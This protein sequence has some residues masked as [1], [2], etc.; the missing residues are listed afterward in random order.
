MKMLTFQVV[1]WL[2]NVALRIGASHWKSAPCLV[3]CS[4][5]ICR[6][7]Y[8]VFNLSPDLKYPHHSGVMR[9]HGWELLAICHHS[10]KSC[11][12]KLC[13]NWDMF[14]ICASGDDVFNKSCDLTK[15]RDWGI[16]LLYEPELFIT[17]PYLPNLVVIDIAVVE[18]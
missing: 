7:R 14:L 12:H 4:W 16:K 9:I 17:C 6:C 15:P 3:W 1:T 5:V 2:K 13:N 11:N 18:I 8:N 10:D